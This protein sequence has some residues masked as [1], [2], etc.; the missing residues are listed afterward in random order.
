[1]GFENLDKFLEKMKEYC[2]GSLDLGVYASKFFTLSCFSASP[3]DVASYVD[4]ISA[5]L[6]RLVPKKDD[7]DKSP[8]KEIL[9]SWV[10]GKL[11]EEL[12]REY[13]KRQVGASKI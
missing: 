9:I 5:V 6:G 8:L 12:Q 3:T 10:I 4:E 1:M 13:V 7:R 2:D 11:P